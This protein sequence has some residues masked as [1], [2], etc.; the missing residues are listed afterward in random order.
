MI[1]MVDLTLADRVDSLLDVHCAVA[2]ARLCGIRNRP[3]WL[4]RPR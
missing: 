4:R 2:G 1:G 3:A